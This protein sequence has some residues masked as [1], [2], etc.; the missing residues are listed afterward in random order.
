MVLT[1]EKQEEMVAK[2]LLRHTVAETE[3]FIDGMQTIIN[4]INKNL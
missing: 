1:K 2:Y 4:Y 3:A